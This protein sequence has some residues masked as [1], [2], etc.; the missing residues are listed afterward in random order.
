[1][2]H[3]N[4]RNKTSTLCA[5]S[6]SVSVGTTWDMT[7]SKLDPDMGII[8]FRITSI[9]GV[10]SAAFTWRLTAQVTLLTRQSLEDSNVL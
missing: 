8:T 3:P 1:M 2:T 5:V 4:V 7:K 6:L 9:L 10:Q